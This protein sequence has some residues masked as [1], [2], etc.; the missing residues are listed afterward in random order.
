MAEAGWIRPHLITLGIASILALWAAYA[1]AGARLLP[2]LPLMR[3]ALVTITSI[4]LLRGLAAVP[5]LLWR[6]HAADAFLIWSSLIVLIF[7]IVHGVGTWQAW[8]AL[9]LDK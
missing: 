4:Y 6:P 8:T 5:V 3:L 2:R 9:S 1:F 7:G